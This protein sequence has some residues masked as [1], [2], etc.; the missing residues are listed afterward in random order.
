MAE[1]YNIVSQKLYGMDDVLDD[2]IN[3]DALF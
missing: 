1:L 3:S 2:I